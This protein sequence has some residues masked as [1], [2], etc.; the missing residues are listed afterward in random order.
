MDLDDLLARIGQKAEDRLKTELKDGLIL[1]IHHPDDF[2]RQSAEQLEQALRLQAQQQI[3]ADD[4]RTLLAK[5]R[6]LAQLEAGRASVERR[7]RIQQLCIDLIDKAVE[8]MV[9]GL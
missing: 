1:A 4:V 8:V 7:A 3:G 5:Q 6:I 9:A 2:V